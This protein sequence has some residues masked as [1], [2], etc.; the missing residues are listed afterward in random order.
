MLTTKFEKMP[1]FKFGFIDKNGKRLKQK[2]DPENPGKMIPNEPKTKEEKSSLTP[3]HRLVFNLK[4][5]I[6]M[7]PFGKTAFASYAVALLLLKEETGLD[8]Q[9]WVTYPEILHGLWQSLTPQD[10][11]HPHQPP[12]L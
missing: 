9:I 5:I 12:L 10:P 1:A 11:F 8:I 6:G 2:P 7:V 3:L 4:K